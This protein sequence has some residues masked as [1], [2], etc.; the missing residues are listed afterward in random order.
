MAVVTT[1][2]VELISQSCV[3]QECRVANDRAKR[4]KRIR[5]KITYVKDAATHPVFK[6]VISS[7]H[8]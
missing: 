2:E 1:Y 5:L 3:R 6:V 7:P 8:L 4:L